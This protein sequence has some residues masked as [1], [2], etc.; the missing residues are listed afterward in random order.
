M[1]IL[2]EDVKKFAWSWV[3]VSVGMCIALIGW[4]MLLCLTVMAICEI[5]SWANYFLDWRYGYDFNDFS[6][7]R[8]N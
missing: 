4:S 7:G 6:K 8:Q 3:E 2:K 1:K 5:F